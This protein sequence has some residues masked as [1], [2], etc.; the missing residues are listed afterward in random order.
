MQYFKIS[1]GKFIEF[2]DVTNRATILVK[3]DLQSQKINLVAQIKV[4]P[5]PTN[6]ELLKWAKD[7]YPYVDHSA[8]QAELDRIN[9]ILEAI[10]LI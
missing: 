10:K 3:E 9:S 7:N 4:N 2:D 1:T 5:M 6:T 8:E